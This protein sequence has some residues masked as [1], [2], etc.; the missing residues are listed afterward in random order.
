MKNI[1]EAIVTGAERIVI[2]VGSR[3]LIDENGVPSA[4]RISDLVNE[5]DL[6]RRAGKQVILVTSGSIASGM[7]ILG[8]TQ[9]PKHL[10]E[11][12]VCAATGQSKLMSLYES[13]CIARG[14]H[15]AQ[16]L[17]MADDVRDR[18]RHLNLSNCISTM[19]HQGILPIINENDSLSVEEIRFGENDELAA[20]VAI[21]SRAGLTVLMTSVDGL[22]TLD[23]DGVPHERISVVE[24]VT[25]EEMSLAGGTDGN[26]LSTGGMHTKLN[27][28]SMVN[29]VGESL[30]IID[31]TEFKEL[32]KLANAEDIGTIF[33]GTGDRMRSA[34][35]WLAF[36]S[37]TQGSIT[38]DEGAQEALCEQGRSLL[39]GGVKYVSEGFE[40]G[41]IVDILNPEG[42]VIAKGMTNYSTLEVQQISGRQCSEIDGILGGSANYNEVVHRDNLVIVKDGEK[43]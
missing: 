11:L 43:E 16:L 24:E 6:L 34:K 7:S 8:M 14:F 31:G 21:M 23:D 20:L 37:E 10:P 5:I 22:H 19:L 9:R 39:P 25:E 18:R 36:F 32:R 40:K 33:P 1:R 27:A 13:A 30:W 26:E 12:Q 38:V 15:C 28:A 29:K 42:D 35:R 4:E 41:D 2:K 3:L 17:L